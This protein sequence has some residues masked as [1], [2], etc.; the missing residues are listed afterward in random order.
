MNALSRSRA[1]SAILILILPAPGFAG[2]A[3]QPDNSAVA[4]GRNLIGQA[5][6]VEA[7]EILEART[8][9]QPEDARAWFLLGR[10]LR[11]AQEFDGSERGLRTRRRVRAHAW[12]GAVPAGLPAGAR[13]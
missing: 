1:W 6:Y 5:K 8:G 9:E 7:I 2:Q 4:Q 10:A 3:Q 12:P 11:G 13:R